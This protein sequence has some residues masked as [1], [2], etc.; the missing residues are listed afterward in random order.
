MRKIILL[1]LLSGILKAQTYKYCELIGSRD[2]LGRFIVTT[3]TGGVMKNTTD[4]V[5][6][7]PK[8]GYE[9]F[10]IKTNQSTYE[11]QE[12][13]SDEK[14][15]YVLKQVQVGRWQ[16]SVSTMTMNSMVQAM[17]LMSRAGW[18]LVQVY[19]ATDKGRVYYHWILKKTR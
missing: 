6:I 16:K 5:L 15:K 12:V 13:R 9:R 18:E 10:Y 4:T 14:G 8:I 1:L 17:N 19:E 2:T 7:P 11:G 3:D